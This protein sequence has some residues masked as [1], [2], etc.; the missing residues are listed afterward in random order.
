M[1]LSKAG[2]S[3]EYQIIEKVK[4]HLVRHFLRPGDP[5]AS[6]PTTAEDSAINRTV[7]DETEF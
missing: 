2:D 5:L 4:A 7:T 1:F 3:L 6:E